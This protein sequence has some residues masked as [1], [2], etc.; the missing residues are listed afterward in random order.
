MVCQLVMIAI[1]AGNVTSLWG[2]G[3]LKLIAS[4]PATLPLPPAGAP[5]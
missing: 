1:T 2:N 3:R 5:H 4:A